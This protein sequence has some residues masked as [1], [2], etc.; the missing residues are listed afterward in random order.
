MLLQHNSLTMKSLSLKSFILFF[1]LLSVTIPSLADDYFWQLLNH[2]QT[3]CLDLNCPNSLL[4]KQNLSSEDWRR[5]D[6]ETRK[7]FLQFAREQIRELWPDTILEGDLYA[8]ANVKIDATF[9][10]TDKTAPSTQPIAGYWV[11]FSV[12]AWDLTTCQIDRYNRKEL[13]QCK[14]GR[15]REAFFVDHQLTSK[16][17]DPHLPAYYYQPK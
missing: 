4:Q 1:C 7:T 6:R 16:E 12:E 14:K 10:L 17:S 15:I 3:A 5:L 11:I 9:A 8:I 2:S 13:S